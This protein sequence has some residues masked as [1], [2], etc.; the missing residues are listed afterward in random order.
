MKCVITGHTNGIGKSIYEHFIDK[1]WDVKGM[2]RS[3]GYDI[4]KNQD[5]IIAETAGCDIFV[6]CAYEDTGQLELLNNLHTKV[7]NMI[8]VGS[9]G[10]DWAGIWNGYGVNKFNLQQRCKELSLDSNPEVA[11]IFYLKL[12]FCENANW[13]INV[14]KNYV[15]TFNEILQVVDLW[16]SIPKLFS[17]EFTFKKTPEILEYARNMS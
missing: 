11:N 15:A 3:N 13:S 16:L 7:K 1:G 4:I 17:V 12:A 6:N 9:S 10:A 8:V 5:K 2:S 14:D